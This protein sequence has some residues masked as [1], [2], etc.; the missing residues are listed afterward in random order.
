MRRAV[1]IGLALLACSDAAPPAA[2]VWRGPWMATPTGTRRTTIYYGPWQCTAAW[3]EECSGKCAGEGL[4][5]LGCIW[6]ADIKLDWEGEVGPV[7]IAGG[8]R[9]AVTHCCCDYPTS[10]SEKLRKEW[11]RAREKF[12]TEW[13]KEFG[14]WPTTASGD[15]WPG[16]HVRD[17]QH[18]GSAAARDNVLPVPGDVHKTLNDE[19]RACYAPGSRW[20]RPGPPRP[21]AD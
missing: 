4:Q 16:H 19:Y 2:A 5:S 15:P 21:Y 14:D 10:G 11:D 13:G 18:G 12:R 8:G 20:A 6:V 3:L 17:L 7:P 9:L 1:V